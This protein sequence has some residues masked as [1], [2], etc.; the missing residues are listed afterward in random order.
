MKNN[1][2]FLLGFA[3]ITTLVLTYLVNILDFT[4]KT[5]SVACLTGLGEIPVPESLREE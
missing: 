2:L 5:A 4:A 3:G 1:K